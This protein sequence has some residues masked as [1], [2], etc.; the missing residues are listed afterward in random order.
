MKLRLH[1]CEEDR[2]AGCR[3]NGAAIARFCGAVSHTSSLAYSL[4]CRLFQAASGKEAAATSIKDALKAW[5]AKHNNEDPVT[6]KKIT[7]LCQ[8]PPIRKMDNKLCELL[9]CEQLS[10]ST[11]NIERIAPLPGLKNLKILSLGR[12]N[13]KRFEK[14]EDVA[15]T[16]EE[17]WI[18][19]NS[20]EKCDGL[21][22]MRKLRVIYMSNNNIKSF[23]ELSKLRDL[24]ALEELLLIGNPMYEGFS[25]QQRRL[26]V[27]RRLPKLKKL[28]AIVVSEVEREQA[29]GGGDDGTHE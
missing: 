13:I 22:G 10:L 29:L 21:N 9:A 19:Y 3:V 25:I 20:I 28:D 2:D 15:N 4:S 24:P 11:N 26:E 27:I 17:L 16:L 6:A 1:W 7:L 8:M 5:S 18:S 12:N 14:L 23:D